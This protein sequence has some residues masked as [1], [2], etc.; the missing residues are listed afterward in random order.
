M[1]YAHGNG[2]KQVVYADTLDSRC[3][4]T[5]LSRIYGQMSDVYSLQYLNNEARQ[6]SIKSGL[7]ALKVG[8]I[9]SYIIGYEAEAYACLVDGDTT[10]AIRL[11]KNA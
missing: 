2:S 8:N 10:S 11:A 7:Y 3:N 4:Y 6:A 5:A 1:A 9:R